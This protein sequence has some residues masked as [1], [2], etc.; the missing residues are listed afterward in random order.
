MRYTLK[1]CLWNI[2]KIMDNYTY[3]FDIYKYGVFVKYIV[4]TNIKIVNVSL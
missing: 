1:L 4:D 3:L 2:S